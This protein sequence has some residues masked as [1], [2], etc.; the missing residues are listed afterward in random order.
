MPV[1]EALA[2]ATPENR[3]PQAEIRSLAE[4]WVQQS[5]P[6]L[7][8]LCSVF[9]STGIEHRSFARPLPWYLDEPGWSERADVFERVGTDLAETVTRSLL[10]EAD[11]PPQAIDGIVFVTTTGIATPS[12]E[13]HLANRLGLP[14]T[15]D[16]VPVWGLGCA[17]GVAGLARTADLARADPEGRYLL[18]SLE[19]CSLAFLRQEVS[20][21]MLVAAALF[22]DGAAGA[23]VAGDALAA[24]GPRIGGARSHLWPGT[25]DVMGWDVQD[26]GLGVVFSPRIPEIVESKLGDVVHPFLKQEDAD[27]SRTRTVFHPGGPKVLDAYEDA[28]G[29]DADAL[30]ASRR[31]LAA[32]GNIS[33]P[34]VLFALEASLDAAPLDPGEP[35]LLAA[36]GPGFAAELAMLTGA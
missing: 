24:D 11:L 7:V 13:A 32:H 5:A 1:L 34:T 17:G 27:L 3:V 26:A 31:V 25:E 33:S 28:L 29:L 12:L 4:S 14:A 2:T 23:L 10:D 21:K 36:V 22:S 15:V 8:P 18:V 20:K 9:E 35:A 6:E 16:R 30:A 19:L